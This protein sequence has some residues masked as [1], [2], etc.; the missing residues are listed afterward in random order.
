MAASIRQRI[1]GL[2][3][4]FKG[5]LDISAPTPFAAL[6]LR[7]LTN[8]RDFLI[9]TESSVVHC[10]IPFPAAD[11]AVKSVLTEWGEAPDDIA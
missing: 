11:F 2:P 6:V 10:K 7:A 4:E 9:T 1:S 3:A 5:M 8:A